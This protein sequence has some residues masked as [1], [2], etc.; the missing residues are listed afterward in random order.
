MSGYF[1]GSVS[2]SRVTVSAT[3][4]LILIFCLSFVF[5]L[6]KGQKFHFKKDIS[7][8][9][10]YFFVCLISWAFTSQGNSILPLFRVFQYTMVYIVLRTFFA[11]KDN[12]R[13]FFGGLYWGC[14]FTII[15][16]FAHVILGPKSVFS[17]WFMFR[18]S[19]TLESYFRFY[20]PFDNPLNLT[21]YLVTLA[22][23]F[24]ATYSRSPDPKEKTVN[25]SLI[26]A[27]LLALAATA[28]RSSLFVFASLM[29]II[30]SNSKK[31]V[32]SFLGLAIVFFLIFSLKS[33]IADL[34]GLLQN[35]NLSRVLAVM[36][37]Y[38]DKQR[39]MIWNASV[40][41]FMDN[42]IFGVG[43]NKFGD[44]Y[45]SSYR[46]RSANPAGRTAENIFLETATEIGLVGLLFF[47][48][49]V[50]PPIFKGF[51]EKKRTDGRISAWHISI[52]LSGFLMVGMIQSVRGFTLSLLL[53]SLIAAQNSLLEQNNGST[54]NGRFH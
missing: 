9:L 13:Y 18:D 3:E 15:L 33:G 11:D 42:P 43:L 14:I 19:F 47:V 52:A 46:L 2:G 7:L 32:F 54:K 39:N 24:M 36:E 8:V 38:S 41:M 17:N 48:S 20:G 45:S 26:L 23:L 40:N 25:L 34:A 50:I 1:L 5:Y 31:K 53:F 10:C 49:I 29:L 27:S 30:L 35:Q 28:S 44:Y 22:S 12:T 37:D 51:F 21:C 6:L 4:I 16:T